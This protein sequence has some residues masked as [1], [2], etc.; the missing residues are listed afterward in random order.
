MEKTNCN[1]RIPAEYHID[2]GI[3]REV[4]E[5]Y[6]SKAITYLYFSDGPSNGGEP[7]NPGAIN[8]LISMGAKYIQRAGCVWL[9]D[10]KEL[11]ETAKSKMKAHIDAVH[12]I[13][14]EIV[15]EACLFETC[16]IK[17]NDV[18]IPP[19][20]FEAFGQPVEHGRKFNYKNI[21]FSEKEY[22][23]W[24][25]DSGVPDITKLETQMYFYYQGTFYIDAGFEALH[26]GQVVLMGRKDKGNAAW[27]KVINMVRAY[28]L[29]H[30]RRG[31]VFNN[32]HAIRK[33]DVTGSDGLLLYDFNASPL[34]LTEVEGSETMECTID[35][36]DPEPIGG[37]VYGRGPGGKT[38]SGWECDSL[39]YLVELDNYG[40]IYDENGKGVENIGVFNADP[41]NKWAVIWVWGYDEIS[42]FANQ[43][44]EYRRNW[45]NYAYNRVR[46]LDPSG[47]FS[48][49]GYR[50][51]FFAQNGEIASSRYDCL[52]DRF[53]D[54]AAMKA[55]WEG[56]YPS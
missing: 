12:Q 7:I 6:L 20:V 30:A 38:H 32:A 26:W 46:E 14:P 9:Q 5:N 45:L 10:A 3:S 23:R 34:R 11:N 25:D 36:K 35:K 15:F 28:A 18:E 50:P 47:H 44:E 27:T 1:A 53:N 43:R 54:S 39:P 4:L 51:Y 55:I 13:A 40:G 42:W 31:F 21:I 8:G 48:M 37:S 2:C 52:N 49:P 17:I 19:Y 33:A 24:G 41:G 22:D 16:S 56:S 29:A